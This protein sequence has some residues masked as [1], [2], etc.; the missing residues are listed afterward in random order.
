MSLPWEVCF[1]FRSIG[2]NLL[3][4]KQCHEA[5][6]KQQKSAEGAKG[7]IFKAGEFFL[8]VVK[9]NEEKQKG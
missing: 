8:E 6:R 7:R 5:M 9:A 3:F 4:Y 1:F 2:V